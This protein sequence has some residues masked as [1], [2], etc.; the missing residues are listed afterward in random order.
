MAKFNWEQ[1]K[2]RFQAVKEQL[3]DMCRAKDVKIGA[4]E[5]KNVS[6]FSPVV[7]FV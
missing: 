1:D 4:A 6:V 7:A 5:R 2:E 3:Q